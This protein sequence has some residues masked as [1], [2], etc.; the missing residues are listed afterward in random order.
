VGFEGLEN[1]EG[2][3][4]MD[5]ILQHVTQPRFLYYHQWRVGDVLMWDQTQTIHRNPV[6]SDPNEPRIFLRTIVQ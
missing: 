2:L 1:E 3:A 5:E 6:D 4:L